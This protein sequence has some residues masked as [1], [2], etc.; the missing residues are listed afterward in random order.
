MLSQMEMLSQTGKAA[1]E[2]AD[3]VRANG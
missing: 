1:N 2:S 3:L